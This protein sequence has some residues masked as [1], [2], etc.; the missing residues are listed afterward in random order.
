MLARVT[1]GPTSSCGWKL[2][3]SAFAASDQVGDNE[4][5][6]WEATAGVAER[7]ALVASLHRPPGDP[8]EHLDDEEATL[9]PLAAAEHLTE[10]EW[11]AQ[12]S[13]WWRTLPS[14]HCSHFSV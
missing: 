8:A 10:A 14:S 12:A 13:I 5:P 7:D 6:A 4:V 9:L 3:T 11:G 2:S 1:S